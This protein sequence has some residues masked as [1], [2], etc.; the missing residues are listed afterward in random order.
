MCLPEI[1]RSS[2]ARSPYAAST[3]VS[4]SADE[5]RVQTLSI[6]HRGRG[7]AARCDASG[8][9]GAAWLVSFKRCRL[10][11]EVVFEMIRDW[12]HGTPDRERRRVRMCKWK[13]KH[14][15]QRYWNSPAQGRA[16]H[17]TLAAFA[18]V[19]SRTSSSNSAPLQR[20]LSTADPLAVRSLWATVGGEGSLGHMWRWAY[21][22]SADERGQGIR[23][24]DDL[25][26]A[27]LSRENRET[28][29]CPVKAQPAFAG[30]RLTTTSHDGHHRSTV[31]AASGSR[32]AS[33]AVE[34]P[35]PPLERFRKSRWFHRI[36]RW[37]S[38]RGNS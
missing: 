13:H 5:R 20:D 15:L 12:H 34:S 25:A 36:E 23:A 28:L 30:P 10:L 18:N 27:P 11:F 16:T 31:A 4:G 22:R 9:A 38:F 21:R 8:V 26:A 6:D 32:H 37:S 33:W 3:H 1:S 17:A 24:A 35:E 29:S 7:A 14:Q 19:R 2:D